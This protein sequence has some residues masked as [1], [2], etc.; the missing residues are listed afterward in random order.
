MIN[1]TKTGDLVEV[2]FGAAAGRFS[3]WAVNSKT[4]TSV[5]I[6]N[7][8]NVLEIHVGGVTSQMPLQYVG[9][10][11]GEKPTDIDDFYSKL[12]VMV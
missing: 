9:E 8:E 5:G 6:I 10:I 4:G 12:K 3:K 2:D 7:G 1:I 11:N